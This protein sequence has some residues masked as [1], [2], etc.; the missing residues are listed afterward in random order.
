MIINRLIQERILEADKLISL[1]QK[2][3]KETP[4]KSWKQIN[5]DR[6]KKKKENRRYERARKANLNYLK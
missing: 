4:I 1:K 2:W 6:L 5:S 3:H